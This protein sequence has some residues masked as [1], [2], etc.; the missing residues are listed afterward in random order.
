MTDSLNEKIMRYL[1][2]LFPCLLA[3]CASLTRPFTDAGLGAV[4]AWIGHQVSD[5]N[6]AATAG[7]AA[8]GV[9]VGEG[10][11]AWKSKREQD[12]YTRGL[13]KSR[14]DGIKQIYWNLQAQQRHPVRSTNTFEAVAPETRNGSVRFK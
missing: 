3:G 13:V 9:L 6:V 1:I 8:A 12:A 10:I 11:H 2:L 14:S 4:G 5:G 7:G